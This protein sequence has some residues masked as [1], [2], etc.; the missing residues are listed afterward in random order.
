[1]NVFSLKLTNKQNIFYSRITIL[2]PD[3]TFVFYKRR[4][5][6]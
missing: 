4:L 2:L 5:R 6:A 3:I 1:M